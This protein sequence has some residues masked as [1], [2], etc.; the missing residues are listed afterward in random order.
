MRKEERAR[1][2]HEIPIYPIDGLTDFEFMRSKLRISRRLETSSAAFSICCRMC[3]KD[4]YTHIALCDGM[5]KAQIKSNATVG[6]Y[7]DGFI[8]PLLCPS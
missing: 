4:T 5:S 8:L 7:E 6:K 3:S 1:Y 2:T